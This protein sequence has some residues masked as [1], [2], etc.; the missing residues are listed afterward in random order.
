[1]IGW[2]FFVHGFD[3]FAVFKMLCRS[4][5]KMTR[6]MEQNRSIG[7]VIL[8]FFQKSVAGAWFC[9]RF[10][11]AQ[12]AFCGLVAH[13]SSPFEAALIVEPQGRFACFLARFIGARHGLFFERK[14]TI[15]VAFD[16]KQVE[17][18]AVADID[19]AD[20][21]S[22]DEL[23]SGD[24]DHRHGRF[25]VDLLHFRLVN[26]FGNGRLRKERDR[27]EREGDR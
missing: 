13:F 25:A 22:I 26:A 21:L 15:E 4:H 20:F 14:G 3:S 27:K 5:L 8:P 24:F 23:V 6:P 9:A 10:Q 1:M 16:K 11:V 2:A 19:G 12:N 17:R 18:A 7:L